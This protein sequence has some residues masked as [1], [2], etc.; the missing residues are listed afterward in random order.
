MDELAVELERG[1]GY[2]DNGSGG[3][4]APL[5]GVFMDDL[6]GILLPNMYN[7][8]IVILIRIS[9]LSD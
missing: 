2:G 5:T 9:I 1:F 3:L 6:L 8:P 7:H 4:P